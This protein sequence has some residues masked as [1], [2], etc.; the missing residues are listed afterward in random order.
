MQTAQDSPP[1]GAPSLH[2]ARGA[3]RAVAGSFSSV[4]RQPDV[5]T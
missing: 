5:G 3:S 4:G 2:T 1:P